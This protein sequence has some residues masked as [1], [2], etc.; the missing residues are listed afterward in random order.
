MSGPEGR[1]AS[2]TPLRRRIAARLGP[3][4]PLNVGPKTPL[5]LG[6]TPAASSVVYRAPSRSWWLWWPCEECGG[7]LVPLL[8]HASA[9]SLPIPVNARSGDGGVRVSV[10]PGSVDHPCP[11]CETH[12]RRHAP[13][14]AAPAVWYDTLL[15]DWVVQLPLEGLSGGAL[16]PLEINFFDA[17]WADV[18]RTAADVCY[19][20]S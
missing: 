10:A 15:C 8:D 5:K 4:T 17:N 14:G 11:S 6:S 2:R 3:K 1:N 13:A 9:A 16:L 19:G 18:Y 20:D 12:R 7:A